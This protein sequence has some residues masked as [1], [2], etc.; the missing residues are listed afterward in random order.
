MIMLEHKAID[1]ASS[2]KSSSP[3]KYATALYA[4]ACAYLKRGSHSLGKA[5]SLQSIRLVDVHVKTKNIGNSEEDYHDRSE[6][7]APLPFTHK[8]V[9]VFLHTERGF[10]LYLYRKK[11]AN[12]DVN[13]PLYA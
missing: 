9:P 2:F 1:G 3:L 8:R 7:A 10:A 5:D 12:D 6:S 4:R 13:S 11:I